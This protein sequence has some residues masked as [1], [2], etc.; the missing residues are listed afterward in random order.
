MH[1]RQ[2]AEKSRKTDKR[3]LL[4]L[5]HLGV[6]GEG[7]SRRGR[8]RRERERERERRGA[9]NGLGHDRDTRC[10]CYRTR[11]TTPH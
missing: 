2:G 6:K 11:K 9:R 5:A 4:V 10:V 3:A 1:E 8:E 7:Q